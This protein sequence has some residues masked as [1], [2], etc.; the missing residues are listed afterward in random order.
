MMSGILHE[1][2]SFHMFYAGVEGSEGHDEQ[3]LPVTEE[4]PQF[5]DIV[6]RNIVCHGAGTALLVNGLPEMPLSGLA[7]RGFHAVSERGLI[8]RHAEAMLLDRISLQTPAAPALQMYKCSDVTVTRSGDL[9][10]T[11]RSR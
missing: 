2:V 1:A 6:L 10:I 8:L 9:E 5:R 7:V 3:L 11:E 4:T